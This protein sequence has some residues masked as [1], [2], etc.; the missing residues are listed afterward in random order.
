MKLSLPILSV[1][2]TLFCISHTYAQDSNLSGNWMGKVKMGEDYPRLVFT[3]TMDSNNNLQ[4]TVGSPDKGIKGIPV[5]SIITKSDSVIFDISAAM[6]KFKGIL[7]E[8][9]KSISGVW[10]EGHSRQSIILKSITEIELLNDDRKKTISYK[11][12]HSNKYYNFYLEDKDVSVLN[13]LMLTLDSNYVVLTDI[14]KTDFSDK[15][16]VIIYPDIEKFHKA[17]Y[18]EDAP[19]WVV[20]AAGKN[21]LKMVSPLNPGT[22]HDYESL[23]KAIVH[24]LSHTVFINMR[25]QGQVGLPKWLNE[26]FAFYYAKQLSKESKDQILNNVTIENIPSWSYLNKAETV[27]FGENQGYEY[28]A[29]IVEF[30][31]NK[32]GYESIRKLILN[33]TDF[34]NI[35]GLTASELE[36]NWRNYL[37]EK[38]ETAINTGSHE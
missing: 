32:Y 20:G 15:I 13:D 37:I 35:F 9:K 36:T 5:S 22:V 4:G 2:V 29:L 16:D 26:G 25:P 19:D 28:S 31:I 10:Q 6:A 14:M 34:S 18:L 24:E 12:Q 1:L 11:L 21:E 8:D 27:E 17:I 7:S 30:I 3:I 33:P 23:I 38:K